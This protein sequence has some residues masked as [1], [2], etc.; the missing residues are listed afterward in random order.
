MKTW[1][2]TLLSMIRS[3]KTLPTTSAAEIPVA[4]SYSQLKQ[5][6]DDGNQFIFNEP[7][8]EFLIDNNGEENGFAGTDADPLL[9][10]LGENT[11]LTDTLIDDFLDELEA[12]P[13]LAISEPKR[14]TQ[15][16]PKIITN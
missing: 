5:L 6:Q 12:Y 8:G 9:A 3:S 16:S 4:K 14:I 13:S 1:S 7:K 15:D 11:E 2:S 10:N